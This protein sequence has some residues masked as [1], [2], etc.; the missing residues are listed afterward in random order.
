MNFPL[1]RRKW[2]LMEGGIRVPFMVV[3]P[4]ISANS[5]SS[6]PVISYDLL[7]TFADLTGATEHL[8]HDTDGVSLRP[9]LTTPND[10]LERP[11]HGLVFH[12]PHYNA[13]GLNEPHSAIRVNSLKL[14]RF[15]TSAR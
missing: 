8:S 1:L 12:F 10:Q 6:E 13:V 15:H 9:L 4:S 14:V 11:Q 5:Q 3:G 2:D 7:P